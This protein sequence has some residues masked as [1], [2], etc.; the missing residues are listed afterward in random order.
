MTTEHHKLVRDRIPETI[1]KDGETPVTRRVSGDEYRDLLVEKLYEEV[2]EFEDGGEIEELADVL[3]VVH[4]LREFEGVSA[5][6][7]EAVRTRKAD[8]RGGFA[9]G[10][11]LEEVRSNCDHG[12]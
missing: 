10:I 12:T 1:R 5:A 11:V 2:G 3:E 9:E 7:L 6:E 8:E 4:A